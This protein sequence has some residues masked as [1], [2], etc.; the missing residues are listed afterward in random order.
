M[1]PAR[2]RMIFSLSTPLISTTL[3]KYFSIKKFVKTKLCRG[4]PPAA[5]ACLAVVLAFGEELP[6]HFDLVSLAS[7]R[8]TRAPV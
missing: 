8:S 4:A 3:R 7:H 6:Y 1:R 2:L 5:Q